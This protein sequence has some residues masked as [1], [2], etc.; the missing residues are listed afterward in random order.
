ML[1]SNVIE[2]LNHNLETNYSNYLFEDSNLS[3]KIVSFQ[4]DKK[5]AN[6]RWYKYKEAFSSSLVEYFINSYNLIGN[7]ILDPFAGIGTTLF[8]ASSLGCK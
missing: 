4:A 8:T 1:E 2:K 6:Y 3:R 7:N 5:V